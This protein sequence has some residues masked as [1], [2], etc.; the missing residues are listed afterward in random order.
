MPNADDVLRP[1]PESDFLSKAE[2]V[3][4]EHGKKVGTSAATLM[5]KAK[6]HAA[7]VAGK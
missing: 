1:K 7:M 4:A 6:D 3:E 2:Q 5:Q